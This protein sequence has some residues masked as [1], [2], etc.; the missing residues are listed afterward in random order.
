MGVG[1]NRRVR[2]KWRKNGE[3][4]GWREGGGGKKGGEEGKMVGR[5]V[6]GCAGGM[7][8]GCDVWV[9]EKRGK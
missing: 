1:E 3:G 4:W 6:R 5:R 9:A 8:V 2:K 7:E